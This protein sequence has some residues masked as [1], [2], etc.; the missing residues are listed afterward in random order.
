MI[1]V[2]K[3]SGYDEK[4]NHIDLI[5]IGYT[6]NWDKRFLQ[7]KLHNPTIKILY[8]IEDGDEED[9][10]EL[11]YYFSDY[12]LKEYGREW[13]NYDEEIIEFFD[14]SENIGDIR[15]EL[16]T[17][18][19]SEKSPKRKYNELLMDYGYFINPAI[20]IILKNNPNE[21]ITKFEKSLYDFDSLSEVE[22]WF[23]E[24][25]PLLF[26]EIRNLVYEDV[27]M[28][29]LIDY[30]AYRAMFNFYHDYSLFNSRMKYI[31]DQKEIL[32]ERGFNALLE[33]IPK[34]YK[35]FIIILGIDK[36]KSFNYQ[37][38]LLER[39][40]KN[41]SPTEDLI[42]ALEIEFKINNRYTKQ[43]IKEKLRNIYKKFNY[44]KTPKA[45]DLEQ[46]FEVRSIL[47]NR[48]DHGYEI[49]KKK[50]NN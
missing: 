28:S 41:Q 32:S 8:E 5:K 14:K 9:E 45:N 20:N 22:G 12:K 39:E 13:F 29:I 21:D 46:W 37:K 48:K 26:E 50:E 23:K 34:E 15:D 40:L 33:T 2:L 19:I 25:Y 38:E 11:H 7:Y 6:N 35:D 3:S 1:Y 30:K 16:A 10:K 42:K 43:E 36:I 47:I 18:S 49:I 4:G 27:Y 17:Y 24:N 44:K 31:C